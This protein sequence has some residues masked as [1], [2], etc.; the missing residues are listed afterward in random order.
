MRKQLL[1][2]ATVA[3]VAI[4]AGTTGASAVTFTLATTNGPEDLSSR[5]MM[6]WR[7]ALA[8]RSGGDLEMDF[9]SGGALGGDQ[10]L[11]QQLATNEIQA[12]IAGPV[13]VHRLLPA[14][15]CL[16]AEYVYDNS[17]HGYRVWTGE[18]GKEVS[19]K[20]RED[21]GIEIVAVGARGAREVT[22]DRPIREPADLAG[23]KIRVTNPLRSQVF[24][25][26][27][28]L[29]G[30]L[31]ISELYGALRQGVFDAQENPI[32]T[33]FG[34]RFYEVQKTI[35]LTGHVQSYNVVTANTAFLD[36][37]SEEQRT[38]YDETLQEAMDWLNEAVKTES[39]ELLEKMKADGVEVVESDVPAFQ[40][41]AQPIVEE[42]AAKNCRPGLL[43]D[44]R[45]AAQ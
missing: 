32:P 21:Y 10:E 39:S 19:D 2:I 26:Y 29:P 3:A 5:A 7:D 40:K 1:G 20:L 14:Y 38:V 27:G 44:I 6:R 22:A 13:V 16:E 42:F 35:N 31:P 23:V 8:E 9:V 43:D 4:V 30:P 11:L 25:A 12:H 17:D 18:L 33:I 15:Q 24:S 45:K 37:L 41:V 28:A 36:S 34:N